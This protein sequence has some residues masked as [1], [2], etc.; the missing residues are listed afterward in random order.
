MRRVT[1]LLAAMA[2]L[3]TLFAA[4]AYA[5]TIV[6]TGQSETLVESDLDDTISGSGGFDDIFADQFTADRDVANGNAGNDQ[7]RAFDQDD[8]DTL[9]GGNGF[10]LCR[11][12]QGDEF[13]SCE[14]I[15]I[16]NQGPV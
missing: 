14:R 7:I 9:N 8:L 6:G 1:L 12:D 3:V 16:G 11:G 4:A 2:M 5:A 13:R 10:D 15:F